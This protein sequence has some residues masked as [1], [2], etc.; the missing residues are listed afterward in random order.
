MPSGW[1][2]NPS[3]YGGPVNPWPMIVV[4]IL[5][6]MALVAVVVYRLFF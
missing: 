5:M 4:L 2:K 3:D 6:V 1:D